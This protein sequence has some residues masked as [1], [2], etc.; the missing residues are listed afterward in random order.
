M[1]SRP[2]SDFH[3]ELGLEV[4]RGGSVVRLGLECATDNRLEWSRVRILLRLFGNFCNFLFSFTP[5]FSEGTLKAVGPFYL[6][7]MP[8]EVKDPTQG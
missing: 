6:V 7:S 5:F 4:G 8:E 1:T 3:A 2:N